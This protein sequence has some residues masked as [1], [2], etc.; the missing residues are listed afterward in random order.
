MEDGLLLA[1][2]F[3]DGPEGGVG[4]EEGVGGHKLIV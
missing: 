2:F 3:E 4:V 1:E